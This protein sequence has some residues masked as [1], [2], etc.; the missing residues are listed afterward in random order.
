MVVGV[1]LLAVV[2]HVLID[3]FALSSIDKVRIIANPSQ[4][5]KLAIYYSNGIISPRYVQERSVVSQP[6]QA[7]VSQHIIIDVGDRIARKIRIDP[8]TK[9]GTVR[10]Y[11]IEFSSSFG[12]TITLFPAD[13]IKLFHC[14]SQSSFIDKGEYVEFISNGKDPQIEII[15]EISF[16]NPVFAYILPVFLALFLAFVFKNAF[17]EKIYAF[18]DINSKSK[19]NNQHY[20]AL[21]GVRGFAAILVLADHTNYPLFKGLG[22]IGVWLFFSLK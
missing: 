22:A 11:L 17:F 6:M 7:G 5:D 3:F 9:A 19:N 18:S 1:V 13:I 21:D 2:F 20:I 8:L 12:N 15:K 14:N 16:Y 10:I 4:V